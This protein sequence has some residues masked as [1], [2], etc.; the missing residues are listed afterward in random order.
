MKMTTMM[1]TTTM[2]MEAIE[3]LSIVVHNGIPSR[4]IILQG[5]MSDVCIADPFLRWDNTVFVRFQ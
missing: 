4:T 3:I 1:T 2:M 5:W